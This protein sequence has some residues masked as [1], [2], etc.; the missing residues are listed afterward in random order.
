ALAALH[1]DDVVEMLAEG[2]T[3]H[4]IEPAV[5]GEEAADALDLV[6]HRHAAPAGDALAGI[7]HERR[8]RVV[9]EAPGLLTRV[10]Q[11]ADAEFLGQRAELAVGAAAA[12]LAV[13]VV[14]AEEQ[15]DDG[16]PAAAH[17]AGVGL[18]HHA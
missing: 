9:D 4:G 14:L 16:L 2:G 13:A 17:A 7:A 12:D 8:R 1:A 10:L 11:L 18:D 5:L 15:L 6:A 3:D